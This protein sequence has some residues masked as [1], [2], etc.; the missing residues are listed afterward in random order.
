M[1]SDKFDDHWFTRL[2]DVRQELETNLLP[3]IEEYVKAM[4]MNERSK[5][6]DLIHDQKGK[7]V[8]HL[9]NQIEVLERR[10]SE[11]ENDKKSGGD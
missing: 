4:L 7:I 9:E 6:E 10:I 5:I 8:K 2:I 11:L 3:T 1:M